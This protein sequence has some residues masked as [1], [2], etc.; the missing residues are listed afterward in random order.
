MRLLTG[1]A[2]A[3]TLCVGACRPTHERANG[4]VAET[5]PGALD[6]AATPPRLWVF[7]GGETDPFCLLLR[8]D[9]SGV[10]YGGF[11]NYN[12]VHW[13]YDSVHH[14]LDLV[15]SQLSPSD[16]SVLR[17]NLA[18]GYFMALD[19][20]SGTLSYS[21]D[22]DAPAINLFNWVLVPPKSL[23]D[24]QLPSAR[25]GCPILDTPGGA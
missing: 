13:S 11:L 24:W 5:N 7:Y 17:D 22:P 23:K 8:N 10:F 21:L 14:R 9:S 12:P 2:L 20:A 1:A 19:T 18:R 25:E 16:Y 4:S 15:L 6:S 3:A